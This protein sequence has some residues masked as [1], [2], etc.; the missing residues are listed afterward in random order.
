[1]TTKKLVKKLLEKV[2]D[3]LNQVNN[4]TEKV[5][6]LDAIY[7]KLDDLASDI[8][9]PYSYKTGNIPFQ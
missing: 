9:V 8:A 1:M 3:L 4:I 6:T 5:A 2:D 7:E